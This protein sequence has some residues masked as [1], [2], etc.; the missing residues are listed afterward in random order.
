MT[1]SNTLPAAAL[2]AAQFEEKIL[3]NG[4]ALRLLPMPGY[5]AVHAIYTTKFGSI[6]RKFTQNGKTTQLPAGVAHF[7]EHKMFE[8]EDGVDAFSLYAQTGASANAYTSFERTSYIFTASDELPRNLDILLSFVGHPHFT[9]ATIAKEQGII[10]QEIKMY[11]DHPEMR[12]FYALLEC[13]YHNHPIR[14]DIAGTVESIGEITPEMLYACTDAYYN[15]ANM[16]LC[17]AGNITMEQL[18]AAVQRAGLPQSPP[19]PTTSHYPEE[20]TTV[21]EKERRFAMSV[22]MPLFGIGFKENPALGRTVKQEVVCD[23]LTELLCGETSTLYRRLYDEG[24]VQPGFGGEYGRVEGCLYFMFSGESEQPET[25]RTLLLE[26]IHRQRR[27]GI[28]IEQFAIV[29][30]ML[31]GDAIADLENV[32]RV[33]SML[34]GS[35]FRGRTPAD[36]LA[37]VASV[38][39]EDLTAALEGM[40][41]EERSVF[42]VVEPGA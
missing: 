6:N 26:E 39:P 7:L 30:K 20:P 32:E 11:D 24:L 22:A 38:T 8:N 18:E 28:D 19:P 5:S 15:P 23:I 21:K 17:A 16:A 34:S 37:A 2:Q 3:P 41:D 25:V 33:A 4:L 13:L 31:Y 40:L 35:Y 9:E 1:N 10:A 27:E 12:C 36:E 42:V 29:K 14:E